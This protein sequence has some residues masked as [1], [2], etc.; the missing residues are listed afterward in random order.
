MDTDF[1]KDSVKTIVDSIVNFK[2]NRETANEA[3]KFFTWLA[4]KEKGEDMLFR[5][6]LDLF[7]IHE[8][9][10]ENT[11]RTNLASTRMSRIQQNL[12]EDYMVFTQ[13]YDLLREV[14]KMCQELE[15]VNRRLA[16]IERFALQ[17]EI[18]MKSLERIGQEVEK[19]KMDQK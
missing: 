3:D 11:R 16:D 15:E 8:V 6:R 19:K 4:S 12:N 10:E 9:N 18:A 1:L 13:L 14:P 2:E 17:T 5:Y 7:Q